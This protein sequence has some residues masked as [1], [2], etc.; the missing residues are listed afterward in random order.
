MKSQQAVYF[1]IYRLNVIQETQ[2]ITLPVY[3]NE[4]LAKFYVIGSQDKTLEVINESKFLKL[5]EEAEIARDQS[6]QQ[7][8]SKTHQR[9]N[10]AHS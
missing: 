5:K 10:S 6:M 2:V 8:K 7:T 4:I 3:L 9:K 1:Y